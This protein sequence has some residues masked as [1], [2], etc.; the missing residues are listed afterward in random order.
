[1]NRIFIELPPFRRY[2]DDLQE[3]DDLLKEIQEALLED[4]E[5]GDVIPGTGGLRKMRHKGKGKGKSGGY[6]ITYLHRPDVEKVYLIVLYA[7]N[8]QENLSEGEKRVLK[9]L[10][11]TLKSEGRRS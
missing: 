5:L 6:R 7:K 4:P 11:E 3:G 10:V 9:H 1:M 8:E 2:L